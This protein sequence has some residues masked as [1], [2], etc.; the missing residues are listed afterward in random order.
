MKFNWAFL[1]L[2]LGASALPLGSGEHGDGSDLMERQVQPSSRHCENMQRLAANLRK[3]ITIQQR[4]IVTVGRMLKA[5]NGGASTA[6]GEF[7][8]AMAQLE[9]ELAQSNAIRAENQQIPGAPA[10]VTRILTSTSGTQARVRSIIDSLQGTSADVS[11]LNTLD[12]L[13]HGAINSNT[14]AASLVSFPPRSLAA[15]PPR[16]WRESSSLTPMI[17][18]GTVGL[19]LL[20]GLSG[21]L[22]NRPRD[23][24]F[25]GLTHVRCRLSLA[26]GTLCGLSAAC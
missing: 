16:L 4:E 25:V 11:N 21:P 2:T 5:V 7:N 22:E 18:R 15:R 12:G 6:A 26:I 23:E 20:R 13:F 1:L 17:H 9:D 14:R 8:A 3:H 10:E 19:G 24:Q